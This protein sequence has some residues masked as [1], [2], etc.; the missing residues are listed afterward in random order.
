MNI[1]MLKPD[2]GKVVY[3]LLGAYVLPKVLMRVKG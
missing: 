3:L 2:L 1:S